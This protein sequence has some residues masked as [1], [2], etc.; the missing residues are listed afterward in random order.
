[1]IYFLAL[2]LFVTQAL[3]QAPQ[4]DAA[5]QAWLNTP[6]GQNF[7][8]CEADFPG[9]PMRTPDNN[10]TVTFQD[11]DNLCTD[12]C[13]EIMNQAYNFFI[14]NG[15]CLDVYEY[16]FG[17]CQSDADCVNPSLGSRVCIQ[18][19]C[20]TSCTTDSDCNTC[21]SEFCDT[22]GQ[23]QACRSNLTTI[24]GNSTFRGHVYQFMSACSQ[25]SD[26]G[27]CALLFSNVSSMDMSN[28]SCDNFADWGCCLGQMLTSMQFC[29]FERFTQ[30]AI[31]NCE[32]ANQT[33]TDLP[34]AQQF[35]LVNV[36]G[37]TNGTTNGTSSGMSSGFSSLTGSSGQSSHTGSTG[38]GGTGGNSAG[39]IVISWSL[40]VGL[41]LITPALS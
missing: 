2:V 34:V 22:I 38:V 16:T 25:N 4:P 21:D 41:L 24:T 12:A 27:A 3:G 23:Q 17:A 35:C 37:T 20:Y 15:T 33:C 30:G 39:T 28:I 31:Y 7:S 1:M 32:G 10:C 14:T 36:N 18:G 5:C 13:Y 9:L 29:A 19:V 40:L 6:I 8:Q 11:Y 26:D